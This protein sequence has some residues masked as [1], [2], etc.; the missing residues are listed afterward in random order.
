VSVAPAYPGSRA[1][2]LVA[3]PGFSGDEREVILAN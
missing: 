3:G 2:E 1:V